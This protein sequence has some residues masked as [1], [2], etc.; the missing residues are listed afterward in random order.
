[1]SG[2]PQQQAPVPFIVA[3]Y[4]TDATLPPIEE[5]F[6]RFGPALDRATQIASSIGYRTAVVMDQNNMVYA[7]LNMLWAVPRELR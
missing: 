4:P 5:P 3:G 2:P 6:S 1:M 7:Q